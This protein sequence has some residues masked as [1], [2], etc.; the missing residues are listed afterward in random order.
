MSIA[1][2]QLSIFYWRIKVK[3][4]VYKPKCALLNEKALLVSRC[5]IIWHGGVSVRRGRVRRAMAVVG[6]WGWRA[7]RSGAGMRRH[8]GRGCGHVAR[9]PR[10]QDRGAGRR[11]RRQ[12]RGHSAVRQSQLLGLPWPYYRYLTELSH[13]D[14][15]LHSKLTSTCRFTENNTHIW[16][17]FLYHKDSVWYCH[18]L[19]V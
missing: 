11:R 7:R 12:V 13:S 18:L 10:L 14:Y 6:V 15:C 16:W 5:D 2:N 4:F 9:P 3:L 1:F 8:G 19:F 17:S